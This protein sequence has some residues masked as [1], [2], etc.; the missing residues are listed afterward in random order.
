MVETTVRFVCRP[1]T[2][3]VAEREELTPAAFEDLVL[4][5]VPMEALSVTARSSSVF[6]SMFSS[7]GVVAA[8]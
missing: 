7:T 5:E 4:L 2:L 1:E 6:G 8:V 3:S